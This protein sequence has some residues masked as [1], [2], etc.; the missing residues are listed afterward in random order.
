MEDDEEREE[1]IERW[2]EEVSYEEVVSEEEDEED[3]E[4][5][6]GMKIYNYAILLKENE[7]FGDVFDVE[8][9]I[10]HEAMWADDAVCDA[11]NRL[12]DYEDREEDEQFAGGT[13]AISYS[14]KFDE[15]ECESSYILEEEERDRV[16]INHTEFVKIEGE[17]HQIFEDFQTDRKSYNCD[18][19]EADAVQK[20]DRDGNEYKCWYVEQYGWCAI[21]VNEDE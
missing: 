6:A 21:R 10:Q 5:E 11:T 16:R 8:G 1:Y 20:E 9:E 15:K 2:M 4:K 17:W 18:C 14:G 7:D 3:N 19:Y 12:R 13:V